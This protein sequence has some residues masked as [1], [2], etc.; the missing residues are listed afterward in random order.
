LLG[1]GYFLVCRLR[2][3]SLFEIYLLIYILIGIIGIL[4]V[5]VLILF[6][7]VGWDAYVCILLLI[8]NLTDY[9]M[10]AVFMSVTLPSVFNTLYELSNRPR[11]LS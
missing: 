4:L 2:L 10:I 5:I 6:Y 8:G 9:L 11:Y 1:E 7:W 3:R